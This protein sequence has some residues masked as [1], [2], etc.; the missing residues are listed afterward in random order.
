MAPGWPSASP[1]AQRKRQVY[2]YVKHFKKNH[3]EI[4]S[5]CKSISEMHLIKIEKKTVHRDDE[6]RDV[7]EPQEASLSQKHSCEVPTSSYLPE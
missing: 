4:L 1:P 6:F 3:M 5:V 7:Q 2:D